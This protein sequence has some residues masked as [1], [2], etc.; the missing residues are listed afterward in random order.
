MDYNADKENCESCR[1][2][3]EEFQYAL[4]APYPKICA[5]E[6]NPLYARMILDNIGG[7]ISEMSAVSLY[8]Y[9]QLLLGS[10]KIFSQAFQ[11]ISIVEMHHL[12]IFGKLALRL[13]ENPRLWTYRGARTYYWTPAYN[14]YPTRLSSMLENAVRSEE[15]AV[16]KYAQQARQIKDCRVVAVL[17][18][19]IEDEE[20]HIKIYKNLQREAGC[21]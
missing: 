14:S 7:N 2:G 5:E 16:R 17:N 10:K 19:I 9:N 20:L 1:C 4:S 15:Q 6:E 12:Q 8:L 11:G 3:D 18:R 21:R 13:G